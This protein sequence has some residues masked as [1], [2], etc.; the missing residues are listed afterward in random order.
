[1]HRLA[2]AITA[3]SVHERIHT[4]EFGERLLDELAE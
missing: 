3:H 4:A 1:M 2:A